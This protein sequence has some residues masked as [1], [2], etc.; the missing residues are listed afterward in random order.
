[1]ASM[2]FVRLNAPKNGLNAICEFQ[3]FK[4]WPQCNLWVSILQK[5]ASMKFVSLNTSKMDSMQFLRLNAPKMALMQFVSLN[6]PKYGLNAICASQYSQKMASI[7]FVRFNTQKNGLNAI[8]ESQYFKKWPQC[9]LCVSILQK[10][11]S[12]QF[13]YRYA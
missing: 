7:Q 3:Y 9:N 6:A 10:M 12:M 5:M 8:C 1:M 11:A 4:K 13:L 2:Q